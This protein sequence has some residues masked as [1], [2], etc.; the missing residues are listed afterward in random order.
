MTGEAAAARLHD[1]VA[2]SEALGGFL[3]GALVGV[4]AAVGVAVV[5]GMAATAVAA[6]VATG[7]LATPLVA[8]AA[9]T[10]GE[11]AVNVVVGG[12]LTQAAEKEGEALGSKRMGSKTGEVSA[13]AS[14]VY[15]N[16]R[17]AAR[18]LDADTC[19]ASKIAQGSK[20]VHINGR[21]AARVGDKLTCGGAITDGSPNVRIGGPTATEA[22]IQS[23]VPSWVRWAVIVA[24]L[25]PALGAAARAIGPAIAEVE[26]GGIERALQVGGKAL[27]RAM[28][29]R[30]G[31][32]PPATTEPFSY[33]PKKLGQTEPG[34]VPNTPELQAEMDGAA[35]AQA[36]SAPGYPDLPAEK[37][38][39][40]GD[41][42]RPW[43]GDGDGSVRRVI[44][45]DED[46]NGGY[47]QTDVPQTEAE[48][49]GGSA[50]LNDW[51]G[52]GGYVE[53][54]SDG[55]RGW[56]GSA[57]PQMSSDGVNVLPG[58]GE[59]I[60]IPPGSAKPGPTMPTPWSGS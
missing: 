50:V 23:E 8:G 12:A 11:F 51:N 13:G 28:K 18:A 35:S 57:R 20:T 58:Q 42:V 36:R 26:A 15:I 25:L 7:G 4:T 5:V 40:F 22:S 55:L 48:W 52:D 43:N 27:G 17:P 33:T 2:H 41:D 21:P 24:S 3:A 6:E 29:A 32:T 14:D 49:R 59:Q 10:V 53:S 16:G 34:A 47:W 31:E 39:T 45:R 30:A 46:A 56:I 44:G 38:A 60:W 19:H 54:P 9:V 37:A 1:P